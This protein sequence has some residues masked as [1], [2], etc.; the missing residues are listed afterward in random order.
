[1]HD[2]EE[3]LETRVKTFIKSQLEINNRDYGM[4]NAGSLV[5]NGF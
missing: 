4:Q 2:V 5:P 1:M 3:A